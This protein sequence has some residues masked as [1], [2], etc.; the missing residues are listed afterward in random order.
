MDIWPQWLYR[1]IGVV[2]LI[3]SYCFATELKHRRLHKFCIDMMQKSYRVICDSR[4]NG[5]EFLGHHSYTNIKWCIDIILTDNN[6]AITNGA[7][8]CGGSSQ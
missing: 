7:I 4:P 8:V 1:D 2:F 3:T 6:V 5:C